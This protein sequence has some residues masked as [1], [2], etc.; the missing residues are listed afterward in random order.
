VKVIDASFGTWRGAV[1][2]GLSY[3]ELLFGRAATRRGAD[4]QIKRIVFVCQGNICRS[5]FAEVR[6]RRLGLSTTSFG[7]ATRSGLPADAAA[8]RA[9]AALGVDI[10]GHRTTA[11]ADFTARPGDLLLAME[12]RQLRQIK[13][14]ADLTELPRSLLGLWT[15][16]PTP[17]LHD[18]FSLSDAYF[19][20][21]F[22]R[23]E[24]AVDR[25]AAEFSALRS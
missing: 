15:L 4:S 21:C 18:P 8:T 12:T 23:I 6:A 5:A 9:A 10:S 22:R 25:L 13:A 24:T 19:L 2:L 11:R 7:L 1:R 14:D 20:T 16:P 17:H 3:G